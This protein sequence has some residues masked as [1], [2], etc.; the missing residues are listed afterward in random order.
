MGL[1]SGMV[2][3]VVV[4]VALMAGWSRVMRRR[5][6]KRIAKVRITRICCD[7]AVGLLRVTVKRSVKLALRVFYFLFFLFGVPNRLR[8]S[9]SWAR[10]AGTTSRSC[11]ATISPNGL[12]SRSSSRL[13]AL[14]PKCPYCDLTGVCYKLE[15]MTGT[16]D[17]QVVNRIR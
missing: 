13:A 2:T 6:R 1:I 8:I 14:L 4:G 3:G 11:A 15:S 17:S 5:S 12:P 9:R 16:L 10:L 7:A